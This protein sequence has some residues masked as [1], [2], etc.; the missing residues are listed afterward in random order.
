M[1]VPGDHFSLLRQG[2]EDMALITTALKVKLGPF[3]WA[4]TVRRDH[5]EY[6]VS[7]VCEHSACIFVCL[8]WLL[9]SVCVRMS[10]DTKLPPP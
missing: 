5:K 3:G 4:E 9:C 7:Q 1:T 6:T 8:R 2:D 10:F